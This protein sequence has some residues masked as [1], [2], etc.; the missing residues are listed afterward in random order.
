LPRSPRCP[1]LA[2]QEQQQTVVVT[3]LRRELPDHV[4]PIDALATESNRLLP[5]LSDDVADAA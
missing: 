2:E 1:T 3:T 4:T 5:P